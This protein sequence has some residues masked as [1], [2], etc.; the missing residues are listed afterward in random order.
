MSRSKL[1]RRGRYERGKSCYR[2]WLCLNVLYGHG[3]DYSCRAVRE[4]SKKPLAFAALSMRP[5]CKCI[6]A[7]VEAQGWTSAKTTRNNTT[8]QKVPRCSA[9]SADARG[10]TGP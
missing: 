7:I 4:E 10:D 2:R 9:M 5:P 1:T 8:R 6:Y 3:R